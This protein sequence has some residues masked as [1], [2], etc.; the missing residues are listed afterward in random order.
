M[1]IVQ[2]VGRGIAALS[3]KTPSTFQEVVTAKFHLQASSFSTTTSKGSM[4]NISK[5]H[6]RCHHQKKLNT[7]IQPVQAFIKAPLK[8]AELS[9]NNEVVTIDFESGSLDFPV[10]WLRDNCR[11][12]TCFDH[13]AQSRVIDQLKFNPYSVP[14]HVN[15]EGDKVQITWDDGHFTEFDKEWLC[16]HSFEAEHQH[17]RERIFH[18]ERVPWDAKRF[19]E[20]FQRFSYDKVMSDDE[21]LLQWLVSLAKNGISLVEGSP[22]QEGTVEKLANRIAFIRRT[23]YGEVFQVK[24]QPGATNTAYKQGQLQMH[25]DMPFYYHMPGSILL[26][27]MVQS[28]IGGENLLTDGFNAARQLSAEDYRVLANTSVNWS[29]VGSDK[30]YHFHS[31]NREPVICEDSLG[32]IRKVNWSQPQRD[33]RFDVSIPE[34]IQWYHAMKRYSDLL[35]HPD[36]AITFKMQ[37]G[38]ILSLDNRRVMHSRKDYSDGA[39]QL[40]GAYVDWDEIYPKIRVLRSKL[41]KYD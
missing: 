12:T 28:E 23:L 40:N 11:C 20:F 6:R 35:H 5:E 33:P 8:R 15:V 25:S 34:A 32:K 41:N 30:N 17:V 3:P 37:P 18:E 27:C 38:D 21:T 1:A 22:L 7:N 24:S 10:V 16:R 36:N 4:R 26:H 9:S 13:T 39:R 29:D 19:N 14:T 2:R 31:I